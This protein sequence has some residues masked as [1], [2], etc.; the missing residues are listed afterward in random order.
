[1]K[2]DVKAV[3]ILMIEREIETQAEL[4]KRLDMSVNTVSE[5]FLGKR[6]PSL[7]T[8]G[9]LCRVLECRPNDILK[10]ENPDTQSV[11]LAG[12]VLSVSG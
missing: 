7:D 6:K 2:L 11:A 8:I 3:K 1:M 9:A 10:S 12:A 4:A 5:M